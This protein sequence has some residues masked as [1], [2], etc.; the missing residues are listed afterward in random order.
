MEQG[1]PKTSK[2]AGAPQRMVQAMTVYVVVFISAAATKSQAFRRN[3]G[4]KARNPWK[5][6]AAKLV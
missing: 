2:V 1:I 5:S 4:L 3:G 6:L